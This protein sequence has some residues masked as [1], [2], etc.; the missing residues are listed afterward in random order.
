MF[1]MDQARVRFDARYAEFRHKA[2]R[3]FKQWGLKPEARDDATSKALC[4]CWHNFVL[5]VDNGK[6]DDALLTSTFWFAVRNTR[7]GR[8]LKTVKH[9]RFRELW[10]HM[11]RDMRGLDLDSFVDD[12]D[13]VPDIVSFRLDTPAWLN[14][15]TPV[16]R[17][18][19]IVLGQGTDT[20]EVARIFNVSAPAVSQWRK[21]LE[22]SYRQFMSV[23]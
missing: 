21:T 16:Q 9:S 6:A 20:K 2:I 8:E 7:A 15:L 4:L 13:S 12:R 5:L 23:E 10:S 22:A 11:S 14:S 3:Y 17:E 18:R 19:A 1:T